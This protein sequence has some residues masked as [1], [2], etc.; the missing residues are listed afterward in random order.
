MIEECNGLMYDER[1]EC[2]RLTTLE[3]RRERA[4]LIEVFK[5]MKGLE[6]TDRQLFF[7]MNL[8]SNRGNSL[9]IYKKRF[10]GE[11]GRFS[12]GNRVCTSW[13]KLPDSLIDT[14]IINVFKC[15]LDSYLSK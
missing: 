14:D 3:R 13:N 15:R 11:V 7:D 4:D 1:L 12:F 2:T 5:I 10:R 6:G 9:K 8:G